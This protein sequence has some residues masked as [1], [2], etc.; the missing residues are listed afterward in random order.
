M[1]TTE[2]DW[3]R[4]PD[5]ALAFYL[6]LTFEQQTALAFVIDWQRGE[7]LRQGA[8]LVAKLRAEYDGKVADAARV[9]D[10][11]AQTLRRGYDGAVV[12]RGG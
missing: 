11:L 2:Q 7:T 9:G 6:S 3:A 1:T 5:T 8:A 4:S 12:T 10:A